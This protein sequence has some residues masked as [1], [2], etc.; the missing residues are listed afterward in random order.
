MTYIHINLIIPIIIPIAEGIIEEQDCAEKSPPDDDERRP[1]SPNPKIKKTV[2]P[3]ASPMCTRKKVSLYKS[4]C[5][6]NIFHQFEG[7]FQRL[8][9]SLPQAVMKGNQSLIKT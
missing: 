1:I 4:I 3:R 2:N 6:K 9:T 5:I 7:K 8:N